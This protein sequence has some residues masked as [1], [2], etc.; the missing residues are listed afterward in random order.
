MLVTT[1]LPTLIGANCMYSVVT[2][3]SP[4]DFMSG[5]ELHGLVD[6]DAIDPFWNWWHQTFHHGRPLWPHNLFSRTAK[7]QVTDACAPSSITS[8]NV[9][10]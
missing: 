3:Y 5:D 2:E 9:I 1:Q 6:I 7:S 4:T 10:N 8:R